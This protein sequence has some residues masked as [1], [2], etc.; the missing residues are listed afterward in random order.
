MHAGRS[1][2]RFAARKKGAPL[3]CQVRHW[4][5]PGTWYPSSRSRDQSEVLDC[6]NRHTMYVEQPGPDRCQ[7]I[8]LKDTSARRTVLVYYGGSHDKHAEVCQGLLVHRVPIC[9]SLSTVSIRA[10][11]TSWRRV[12]PSISR[13]FPCPVGALVSAHA[14][15]NA[16][17]SKQ[18]KQT[19]GAQREQQTGPQTR[20]QR[21]DAGWPGGGDRLREFWV[22]LGLL[23]TG[24][25]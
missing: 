10:R 3:G 20:L 11:S 17:L 14:W 5:S 16:A 24:Q 4:L 15:P 18:A 22:M 25:T 2:H 8:P 6:H 1:G 13:R 9:L 19:T 7:F 23:R 21:V 12:W